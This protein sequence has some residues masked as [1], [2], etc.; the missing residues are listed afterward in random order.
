MKF[1]YLYSALVANILTNI[2]FKMSAL[3]DGIPVKKWGYLAIGLIFGLINSVL[4]T[5]SLRFVNFGEASAVFFALTVIGLYG[6]SYFI[7]HEP[8]SSL[9]LVGVVLI[10][11]GVIIISYSMSKVKGV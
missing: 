3:N 10:T 6:S 9:G 8:V 2:G 4:F 11:T 5:E 7:F 1:V